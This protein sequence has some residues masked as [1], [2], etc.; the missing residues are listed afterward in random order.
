MLT[1][2]FFASRRRHTRC[3]LVTGVQT[4]ALPICP[5]LPP[6]TQ[7]KIIEKLAKSLK[8]SSLMTHFLLVLCKNRRL[9][10]L[11]LILDDFVIRSQGAEG[12]VKDRKRVVTGEIVSVR[13]ELGD[14]R[15]SKKTK[16]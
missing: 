1:S 3:A 12:L 4:C 8:L 9:H 7:R 14:L 5:I 11:K 13:V 6:Q 15:N 10:N 16:N 2:F